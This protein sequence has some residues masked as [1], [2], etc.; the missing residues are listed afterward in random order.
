MV[1]QCFTKILIEKGNTCTLERITHNGQVKTDPY[2]LLFLLYPV[3]ASN[4]PAGVYQ[5]LHQLTAVDKIPAVV[6]SVSG[7]GEVSP[8]TACRIHSIHELEKKGY[9]VIYDHMLV[10]PSNL[11]IPTPRSLA[12]MLLEILPK[13]VNQISEDVMSGIRQRTTPLWY[14]RL[15]SLIFE[16]EKT[17][18]R[19]WGRGIKVSSACDGCGWCAKNCPSGNITMVNGL[20]HFN[21]SCQLCMGCIYGCHTQALLPGA[22]KFFF[23]K[24]GFNLKAIL[25][26]VPLSG[27]VDIEK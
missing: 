3:H 13:K 8:N 26:E 7:G 19:Q 12:V 21:V 22:F 6:I 18:A 11:F 1:A 16:I 25:K 27:D 5:W 14:D 20:P 23:L 2:D 4:A 24:E 9:E 15:F 17:G 10:M